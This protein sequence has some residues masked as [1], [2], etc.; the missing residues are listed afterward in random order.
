[1]LALLLPCLGLLVLYVVIRWAVRDGMRDAL[2]A[3][4]ADRVRSELGL[5]RER[6]PNQP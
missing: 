3:H 1:M 2:R 5:G 6:S 4:E